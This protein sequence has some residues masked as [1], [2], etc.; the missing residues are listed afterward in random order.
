M[1]QI[2]LTLNRVLIDPFAFCERV[3]ERVRGVHLTYLA[4]ASTSVAAA[5]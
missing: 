3:C 2:L 4:N 5:G 1:D